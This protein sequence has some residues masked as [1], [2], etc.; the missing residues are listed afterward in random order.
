MLIYRSYNCISS[1]VVR[2]KIAS[3]E[4]GQ[5]SHVNIESGKSGNYH[6]FHFLP[7]CKM[8]YRSRSEKLYLMKRKTYKPLC[9]NTYGNFNE[10]HSITVLSRNAY[11]GKP[12]TTD[13]V[14]IL[15][16]DS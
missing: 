14:R 13:T 7:L 5:I 3:Y 15:L 9:R 10:D 6:F 11:A 4:V 16:S 1:D 8:S 2:E 12:I